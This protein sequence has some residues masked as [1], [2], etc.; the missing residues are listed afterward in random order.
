MLTD[1][2]KTKQMG[3]ALKFFKLYTQEG[4]EFLNFIVTGDETWGFHHTP[5]LKQQ[6]LHWHHTHSSRTK[7]FKTSI[8][9]K[10]IMASIFWDR[11]GILLVD[12]V[13]PGTTVTATAYCDTLTRLG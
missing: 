6:L 5:E 2:Y 13:P 10:K 11:K 8:S 9:V 4:D 1:D 3:T 12:F 7:Q